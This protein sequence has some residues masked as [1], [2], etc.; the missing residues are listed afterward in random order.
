MSTYTKE[1]Q[2]EL[3]RVALRGNADKTTIRKL[4]SIIFRLDQR[5]LELESKAG[6][7]TKPAVEDV[8]ES[9]EIGEKLQQNPPPTRIK[10]N[11]IKSAMDEQPTL[12]AES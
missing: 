4:S 11:A 6:I 5:L 9:V 1:L 2:D 8:K 12:A 3:D 10:K 7:E